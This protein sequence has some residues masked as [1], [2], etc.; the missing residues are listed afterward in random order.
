MIFN[1]NRC[2]TSLQVIYVN[3]DI[4][5]LEQLKCSVLIV[6]FEDQYLYTKYLFSYN[7]WNNVPCIHY[8]ATRR[9]KCAYEFKLL[10]SEYLSGEHCVILE[11]CVSHRPRR[12][13]IKKNSPCTSPTSHITCRQVIQYH[14]NHYIKFCQWDYR[15]NTHNLLNMI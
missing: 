3:I 10:N 7:W 2:S 13:R 4:H 11:I 6:N 9:K 14:K 12:E 15:K 1:V 5:E 8:F